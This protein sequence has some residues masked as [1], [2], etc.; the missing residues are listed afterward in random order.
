MYLVGVT[1]LNITH[2]AVQSR[3]GNATWV[4]EFIA[5]VEGCT[6]RFAGVL[7]WLCHSVGLYFA[8]V[9]EFAMYI[10]GKL[11]SPAIYMAYRSKIISGNSRFTTNTKYTCFLFRMFG[12]F[13]HPSTPNPAIFSI[14]LSGVE[15]SL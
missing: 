12:F 14:I 8:I 5:V 9:G 11:A 4:D 13:F 3:A 6:K 2:D 7:L 10:C 1:K 15:A